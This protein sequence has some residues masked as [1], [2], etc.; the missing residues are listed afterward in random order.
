M[1]SVDSVNDLAFGWHNASLI[2]ITRIMCRSKRD[3]GRSKVEDP[4]LGYMA[5]KPSLELR[6]YLI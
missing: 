1:S 5:A 2:M 4:P 6:I 3:L